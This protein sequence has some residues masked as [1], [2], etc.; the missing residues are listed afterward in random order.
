[1]VVLRAVS[2]RVAGFASTSRAKEI[3]NLEG[4]SRWMPGSTAGYDER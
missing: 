1:M 4:L 2:L 3:M